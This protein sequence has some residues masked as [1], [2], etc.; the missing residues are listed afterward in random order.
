MS[1]T[2]SPPDFRK[3]IYHILL[4]FRLQLHEKRP[5][6][7][8]YPVLARV[9]PLLPVILATSGLPYQE[10]SSHTGAQI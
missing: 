7:P 8:E 5:I 4:S 2:V 10:R 6:S 3:M 9:V 1:D